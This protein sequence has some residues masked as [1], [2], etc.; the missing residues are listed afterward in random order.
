M[1]FFYDYY[2]ITTVY[3]AAECYEREQSFVSSSNVVL[4]TFLATFID[5]LALHSRK[6]TYCAGGDIDTDP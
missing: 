4:D 5:L 2:S 1:F 3:L 6:A